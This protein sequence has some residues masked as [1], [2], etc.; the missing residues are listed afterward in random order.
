MDIRTGKIEL[1]EEAFGKKNNKE[2][3]FVEVN[4]EDI[5]E[6]QKEDMQVSKYD[7]RSKLGVVFT[8]CRKERRDEE[9]RLKKMNEKKNKKKKKK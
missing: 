8:G 4:Y 2:N 9:R 3:Q 6:K 5:T 7:N 1:L